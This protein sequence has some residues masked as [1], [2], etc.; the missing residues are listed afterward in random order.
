MLR[1]QILAFVVIDCSYLV[2]WTDTS[3]WSVC[4]VFQKYA[5]AKEVW[6]ERGKRCVIRKESEYT[7]GTL[8]VWEAAESHILKGCVQQPFPNYKD[9]FIFVGVR[10]SCHTP[11]C[12]AARAP[13]NRR[14]G[15]ARW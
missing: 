10:C 1:T 15:P 11:W 2:T 6:R 13:S 7:T 3:S 5:V 4:S 9:N 14:L 8:E 12:R